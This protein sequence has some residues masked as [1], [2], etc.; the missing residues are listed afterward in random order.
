MSSG[1]LARRAHWTH[2][3]AEDGGF[4]AQYNLGELYFSGNGIPESKIYACMWHSLVAR[5]AF[6]DAEV[7][8]DLT[9]A[10][11]TAADLVKA[12]KLV[13]TCLE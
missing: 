1:T 9:G 12:E 6:K 10:A 11:M 3:A 8:R 2:M 7:N 4:R 5:Q 13:R